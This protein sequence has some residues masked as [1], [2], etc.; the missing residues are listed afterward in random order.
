MILRQFSGVYPDYI[1][2]TGRTGL[3]LR[4]TVY[5]NIRDVEELSRT[6]QEVQLQIITSQG[7]GI[8]FTLPTRDVSIFYERL[9]A[10]P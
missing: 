10:Q 4:K 8:H 7:A 6:R 9:K 1:V 3:S 5:R 2:S